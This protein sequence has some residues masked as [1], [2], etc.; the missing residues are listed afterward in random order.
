MQYLR[1]KTLK[2][3]LKILARKSKKINP[4]RKFGRDISAMSRDAFSNGVKLL[5]GGTDLVAALKEKRLNNKTLLDI[6]HLKE[7]R[8][9][10]EKN[11][12]IKIGSLITHSEI[13]E[14]NLIK[15]SAPVLKQACQTIGALQIRNRGTL[16]G[17]IGNASPA[18]DSL[19]ALLVL[20]AR[21]KLRNHKKTRLIKLEDFFICP[22][23]T[24]LNSDEIIT[25][26][27]FPK[28]KKHHKSF[29]LKLGQRKALAISKITVAFLCEEYKGKLLNVKIA[30][31]AVAPVVIRAK[32]TEKFLEGKRLSPQIIKKASD[33]IV[34]ESRPIDDIRSTKSYR[35]K[36]TGIFLAEGLTQ[37]KG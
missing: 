27:S 25:E 17:N 19:P 13:I 11:C 24:K 12:L 7:L 30:L 15:K 2:E 29:F 33:I 31:G 35:Q 28:P 22:G 32:L 1:P 3:T 26:I 34:K 4:V 16:G 23:K 9:L 10:K 21:L 37:I 8:Y 14:S 18:A 20:E 5:A 36:M 6:S